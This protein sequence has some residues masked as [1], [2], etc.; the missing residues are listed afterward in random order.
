MNKKNL[1]IL[2]ISISLAMTGILKLINKSDNERK[3]TNREVNQDEKLSYLPSEKESSTSSSEETKEL[4]AV[5]KTIDSDAINLTKISTQNCYAFAPAGW[6]NI[7]SMQSV[8]FGYDAFSPDET[9]MASYGMV[10]LTG[11]FATFYG[12]N[13][14]E[15][16]IEVDLSNLGY[17]NFSWLNEAIDVGNDYKTRTFK[18]I[19]PQKNR[20]V[21]GIFLYRTWDLSDGGFIIVLRSA[22]TTSDKWKENSALA[23]N[24]SLSMR[25]T[26]KLQPSS[27]PSAS[28]N[29]EI[30]D[31]IIDS[32]EKRQSTLDEASSEWSE[33]MLGYENVYSP[34]T[35][36]HYWAPLDSK[37]ETGPSG[38]GYYRV[39]NPTT[40]DV[41]KLENGFGY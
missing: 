10:G 38:S 31:M 27:S 6:A 20:P 1:I 36:D 18:A 41:E 30:S 2:I 16:F 4:M 33:G 11:D 40:G 19:E 14:A 23:F 26:A 15:K 22:I 5:T 35:G 9:S 29:D 17:T 3:E 32:Y 7:E 37:W 13:S 12:L 28:S 25:C 8:G 39:V 34:S 21:T 24:V